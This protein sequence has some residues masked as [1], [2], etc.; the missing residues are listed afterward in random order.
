MNTIKK[1]SKAVGLLFGAAIIYL[2]FSF[3][4]VTLNFA[5]WSLATRIIYVLTVVC[6]FAFI[7]V[8]VTKDKA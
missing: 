3:I 7:Y 4:E 5:V 6:L 2:V 1:I 8:D